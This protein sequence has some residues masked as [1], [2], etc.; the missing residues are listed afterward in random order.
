MHKVSVITSCYKSNAMFLAECI[1]AVL[2]Q[3]FRDFEYLIKDDGAGFD[4]PEFLKKFND[5][6]IKF[7]PSEHLGTSGATN[8]LI[9]KAQGEYVVLQDHD[10]ISMPERL[11][12]C[13]KEFAKD[14]TLT[15][16]S[17]RVFMFGCKRE[18]VEGEP[19]EPEQVT[20]ELMFYQPIKHCAVMLNRQHFIAGNIRMNRNFA[21]ACDYEL[22]SR[23]RHHRHKIIEPV[24]V[25]YRKHSNSETANRAQLRTNH[26]MIVQRNLKEIGISAP[27]E[28]CRMLDPFNRQHFNAGYI[29]LFKS[30]QPILLQHISQELYE[31]KLKELY[32]S[33]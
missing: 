2:N 12:L 10:D 25:R 22:W 16:V 23:I 20:Q 14:P 3:T 24:L 28:L 15:T 5:P 31:R 1:R 13:L 21:Q 9:D 29:E 4:I 11:E 18:R 30:Y 7:I 32:E 8:L 6:R 26:A 33:I 17:S 27:I 19:M